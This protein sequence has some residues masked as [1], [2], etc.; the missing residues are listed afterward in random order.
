V[1]EN[2]KIVHR[3]Y[4]RQRWIDL[5]QTKI[6]MIDGTFYTY[7]RLHFTSEIASFLWYLSEIIGEVRTSQRPRGRVS[8]CSIVEQN[9]ICYYTSHKAHRQYYNRK[10]CIRKR[11]IQFEMVYSSW[12][13]LL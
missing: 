13:D 7:H 3:A 5:R 11:I 12:H 9:V 6:K 1:N 4:L 2:I 10:T 8:T